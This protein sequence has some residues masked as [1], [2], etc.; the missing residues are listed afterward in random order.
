MA[1]SCNFL[2]KSSRIFD[3]VIGVL[4]RDSRHLKKKW[5]QVNKSIKRCCDAPK[6][7]EMPKLKIE[8]KQMLI[9]MTHESQK[10]DIIN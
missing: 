1:Y 5:K 3:V 8:F 2:C 10:A 6:T 7:P 9:T 4:V